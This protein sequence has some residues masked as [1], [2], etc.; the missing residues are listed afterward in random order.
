MRFHVPLA[1][2]DTLEQLLPRDLLLFVEFEKVLYV[3]VVGLGLVI[4]EPDPIENDMC[5][6]TEL[7]GFVAIL[8][9]VFQDGLLP[10]LGVARFLGLFTQL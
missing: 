7:V 6:K 4:V 2:R 10:V 9:D 5:A 1:D 8:E 3:D